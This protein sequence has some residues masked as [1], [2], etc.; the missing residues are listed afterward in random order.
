MFLE[1][2]AISVLKQGAD[3][4]KSLPVC[5]FCLVEKKDTPPKKRTT[6]KYDP[7]YVTVTSQEAGVGRGCGARSGGCTGAPGKVA[8]EQR[9]G[10]SEG[11][12][13]VQ[14][15]TSRPAEGNEWPLVAGL[16]GAWPGAS[17]SLSS[18]SS[19]L[20]S[21]ISSRLPYL[22]WTTGTMTA[23]NACV[24]CGPGLAPGRPL[25]GLSG[26]HSDGSSPASW[27]TSSTPHTLSSCQPVLGSA[28]QRGRRW[29][30]GCC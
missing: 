20:G 2:S 3:W 10:A 5:G 26:G 4:T 13:L 21:C 11:P 12:A 15:E 17:T 14:G 22:T 7:M 25:L 19:N 6:Q 8:V 30:P 28:G 9:S 16:L 1:P 23:R 18:G 29:E 24:G 27:D